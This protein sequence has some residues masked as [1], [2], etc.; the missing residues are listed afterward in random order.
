VRSPGRVSA[1]LTRFCMGTRTNVVQNQDDTN[2]NM[3]E[4]RPYADSD[5]V[6]DII[7]A[8]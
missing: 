6:L 5:S 1:L 2:L 7:G 4:I 8:N 3:S